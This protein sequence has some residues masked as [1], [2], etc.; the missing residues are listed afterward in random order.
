MAETAIQERLRERMARL[1]TIIS[2]CSADGPRRELSEQ[3]KEAEDAVSTIDLLIERLRPFAAYA[4]L[5]DEMIPRRGDNEDAVTPF[6]DGPKIVSI[7][8]GDLRKALAAIEKASPM[9]QEG[10]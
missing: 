2:G 6:H 7:T 10:E 8:Y 1:K 9:L 3:Y 4:A 5:R